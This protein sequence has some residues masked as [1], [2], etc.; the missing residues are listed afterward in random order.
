MKNRLFTKLDVRLN[1]FVV[2][3]VC[4]LFYTRK[5]SLPKNDTRFSYGN[6]MTCPTITVS[7]DMPF[8][9]RIFASVASLPS[10]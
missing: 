3:G 4:P 7:E 10:P 1:L 5:T 2:N 9:A 8:A 6:L